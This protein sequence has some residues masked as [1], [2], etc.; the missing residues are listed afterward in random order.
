MAGWDDPAHRLD[1]KRLNELF[2]Q[3]D[4]QIGLARAAEATLGSRPEPLTVIV[5]GGAA[6]CYQIED[7]G[8]GDVDIIYPAMPPEL[9]DAAREVRKRNGL[10]AQ[11]LNDQ[12]RAFADYG[13]HA[14]SRALFDGR[15]IKVMAPSDEYLLG[16][17]V[18][19]ARVPD[20]AD[21]VWLMG[22]TGLRTKR[23]LYAAAVKVAS[24]IGT[25]W[26]PE[27]EHRSFAKQCIKRRREIEKLRK[28]DAKAQRTSRR[29]SQEGSDHPQIQDEGNA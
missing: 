5:C 14:A 13:P 29:Q 25:S 11:W 2:K 27:A 22:T 4:F 6:M 10:S 15:H 19:A 16:M 7:R 24:S 8:T 21:V 23:D 17:K 20:A 28:R 18:Q 12:P 3:I 1:A 26:K 9:V